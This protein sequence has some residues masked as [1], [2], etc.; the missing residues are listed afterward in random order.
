MFLL[1]PLLV[2]SGTSVICQ[3]RVLVKISLGMSYDY[4]NKNAFQLECPLINCIP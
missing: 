3:E 2:A 4:H 1:N